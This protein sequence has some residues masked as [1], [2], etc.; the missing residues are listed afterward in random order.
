MK[1]ATAPRR[2]A[3]AL[4]SN[5]GDRASHLAFAASHLRTLL[6]DLVVSSFVETEAEGGGG[7]PPYL[8]AAAVGRSDADP[9]DLLA[10]CLAIERA[11]GRERPYP[12]APRTLDVDLILVGELVVRGP[13]IEVP[14][15]RF[16]SR[17][18]VLEPLAAIA[19][20]LV[21]PVSGCTV[22]EMLAALGP[23]RG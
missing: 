21:D 10:R 6:D 18:F 20:D 19:A 11:A 17:R 15:P 14:H 7:Q 22:R 12:R 8:N 4:G 3:V 16:R 9:A 2:I 23:S 13:G 5:L 1:P